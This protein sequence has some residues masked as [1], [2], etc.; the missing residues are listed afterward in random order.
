MGA[1]LNKFIP[2][3]YW[4]KFSIFPLRRVQFTF[5]HKILHSNP[6]VNKG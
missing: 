6:V 1:I 3:M 5:D 4:T 2:E